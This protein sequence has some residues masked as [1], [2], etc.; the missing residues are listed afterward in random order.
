MKENIETK[1]DQLYS[2]V[3]KQKKISISEVA[4]VLDMEPQLAEKWGKVLAE[5]K[6]IRM[7]YPSNILQEPYLEAV[8]EIAEAPKTKK[9]DNIF[10]ILRKGLVGFE[11]WKEEKMQM[12]AKLEKI[13]QTEKEF[14]KKHKEEIKAQT[15][16]KHRAKALP[17]SLMDRQAAKRLENLRLVNEAEAKKAEGAL[18]EMYNAGLVGKKLSDDELKQVL[19]D[20]QK[21]I[22][23]AQAPDKA[24]ESMDK[25]YV[26]AISAR[27]K[28]VVTK[29]VVKSKPE[30]APRISSKKK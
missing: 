10:D 23:N 5:D 3:I 27:A 14:F 26:K 9:S 22:E 8:A 7:V 28:Q 25:R 17:S 15:G 18:L 24:K 30:K 19:S 11:E 4:K 1:A 16:M 20:P 13:E 2:M 29:Q 12:K 21:A 6:F